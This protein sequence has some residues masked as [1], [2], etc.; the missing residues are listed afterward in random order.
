MKDHINF[1][2]TDSS[3]ITDSDKIFAGIIST[4]DAATVITDTL[5]GGKQGLDVY[6]INTLTTTAGA[7]KAEDAAH[8]T[9]DTGNFILAV[10]NH[11][12][13]ALHSADGDYAALQVDDTGR[14][15]VI[16]DLDSTNLSEKDEDTAHTTGDTGSYVLAVR[17]DS[18]AASVSADGDYG[19][20]K[21][22]AVGSLYVKATDSDAIL[23][24]IDAVLD[25]IKTDTAAM[26]VDLAAIEVEQLAQGVTLDTIA[27]DTTSIDATLTA[28]SKSEDAAHVSGDQGIQV[29]A[30]RNDTP[31]SLVSTDGDYGSLQL[32]AT[33]NLRVSGSFATGAEQDEDTA[34]TTGDTGNFVLAVRNDTKSALAGTDGDYIPFQMNSTGELYTVDEAGNALLTTIDADT[35]VIAGD[36]TSMDAT[37]TAL[38][39]AEDAAHTTGDQGLQMLAVRQ[40]TLASSVSADGDYAS[41]KVDSVGRLYVTVDDDTDTDAALANTAIANTATAV[42]TSATDL[43][44]TDLAAR[45]YAFIYNGGNTTIYVGGAAPTVA[46]GFPIS[47]GS[48]LELRAGASINLG[49]IKAAGGSANDTRI[50]ELS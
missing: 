24:T 4:S 33:G 36:T 27:G 41:L 5:S 35:G 42:G 22:D 48:T 16:A 3:T 32:D 8:T 15:R 14:L 17:Q 10:A 34:H 45:K 40:D 46:T 29:L 21:L 47:P 44:G 7:E 18:L 37:L 43:V 6:V 1:D 30:V 31:G 20:F 19:S 2:I 38:S 39:K 26:V 50:L 23:T 11:T 49:A 9:G 13:G 25:T 28:L 12:E